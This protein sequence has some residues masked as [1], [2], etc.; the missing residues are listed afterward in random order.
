[1]G[2]RS[3]SAWQRAATP[4]Q[5]LATLAARPALDSSDGRRAASVARAWPGVVARCQAERLRSPM[6]SA[7]FGRLCMRRT[8]MA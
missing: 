5:G 3:R 2:L 7:S 6:R 4:G 1:M 8:L